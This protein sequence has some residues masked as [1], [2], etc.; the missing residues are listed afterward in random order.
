[1]DGT[2]DSVCCVWYLAFGWSLSQRLTS[3]FP[4]VIPGHHALEN[5]DVKM[6][7]GS[8]VDCFLDRPVPKRKKTGD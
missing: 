5:E 7:Q 1:M 8:N 6:L 4:L 2:L 3:R